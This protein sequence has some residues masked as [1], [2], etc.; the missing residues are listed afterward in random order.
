VTIPEDRRPVVTLQIRDTNNQPLDRAGLFTPGAVSVNF[1]LAR[2]TSQD[3]KVGEYAPYNTGSVTGM[4]VSSVP[5]VLASATQPKAENNGTW[6]E[7]DPA[8]GTYS[9]RF[10]QVLPEDY[11]TTK[12]H[13]LAIYASRTYSGVAYASDPIFHFRPDGQPVTEKR[14]IVTTQACNA[15]HTTL[16]VHGGSR[17][18]LGLCITCHVDGMNDPESGNSLD[19]AQMI[20]KIHSGSK[21][22]SVVAGAPYKIIGF[23]NSVN[24]YS[25]VVFPQ[26][27]ENCATCHQGGAD[28]DRWKTSF[29]RTACGS[30]HDR[31]SFTSPAPN[32][33]TVHT[34]S[35]QTTDTLCVNCHAEGMGPFVTLD[36]D[37]VKVHKRLEEMPLRDL[38]T[39]AILATPPRLAG[40][41]TGVAGSAPG[42]TP[43]VSFKVTVDEQPYDILAT[44]LNR[45]R[46]TFAG[47]TTDYAGYVQYTAQGSGAVGTLAAGANPG[48]FTWTVP[49]G[50]TMTTIAAACATQESGSFAIGMEGR[51]VGMATK[52]D[53]TTA[54]VNYVMHNP[55][56]YFA[57]T[58]AQPVP[59]R[60]A[61]VV[62]NCNNCHQDLAAH[63]G[64]RNDPEYCVLCHN[65]NKDT[66]NI[67]APS[68]G[69]TK[70]TTSLRLSHMVHRIH[71]GENGSKPYI[72]GSDDF[73]EVLFPGDLKDCSLC[74]VQSHYRLP[75]PKLLPS[76]MTQI[77]NLQ[78]RVPSTDYY[79]QATAAAC[80]GCHDSDDTVAHAESMTT[81]LGAESCTTCHGT[82]GAYD[83]DAVHARPGL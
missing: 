37:V 74:H 21:L 71:T 57:V 45:L 50:V 77:D 51:M 26:A 15:C 54:M 4:T 78:A 62:E 59:R 35:Q 42:G 61:V 60:Q 76:H 38:S 36:T 63:G 55:V 29:S 30:C 28:S 56:Y 3:G 46:F 67:P 2:L 68:M 73:S 13:T 43:V 48:E 49:N 22:P 33:Y 7:L 70:L 41:I 32:G 20:H 83:I 16:R 82:G 27:L 66:T 44:P 9:Y 23:N 18:E 72:V 64:S 52:P 6:T 58:D 39:N 47:P 10:T 53:A 75:L 8:M 19:L 81:A 24:D 12:T 11:D 17:R 69:S 25:R 34:G 65:A 31:V 5:P 80:T 1:V 40:E 14:E 79:L